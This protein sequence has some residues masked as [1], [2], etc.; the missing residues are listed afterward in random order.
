VIDNY[1]SFT[2]NLAQAF[3]ML[4]AEVTI[5]RN[6]S[7]SIEAAVSIAPTHLVISPGPGRPDDGGVSKGLIEVMLGTIPILGV[8]LGHQAIAEVCGGRI[9]AGQRLLHGK[10]GVVHHDGSGLFRDIPQPFRAGRYHSLVVDKESLP[11]CLEVSAT[12]EVGEIMG[13][14]H[15]EVTAMGVQ[16]H[17]ESLL[18]PHGLDLM[19]NFLEFQ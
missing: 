7:L 2:F 19:N 14:R 18:T 5:H 1:D 8:C 15:R 10:S 4:G 6:D 16:F 17:P 13:L 9:V 11:E 3:M 12:D